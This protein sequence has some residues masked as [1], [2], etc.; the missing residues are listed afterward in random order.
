M[1]QHSIIQ[2][3][4]SRGT[5]TQTDELINRYRSELESYLDKLLWWNDRVNLV[6][7]GVPRETIREHIRHSLLLSTFECFQEN[8]LFLDTGTGGGLPGIPLAITHPDK[9]FVLNDLVTKKC[10]A[11]KQ[12][13]RDLGLHNIGIIDGSIQ[14]LHHDE[15]CILISK[16][17][18]KIGG[19]MEMTTHLSW[20]K[21]VLYKGL[22]FKDELKNISVPLNITCFDLSKGSDFYNGKAI[23]IVEKS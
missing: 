6:S 3:T 19:L 17:A 20:K 10:L 22:D 16:H 9:H 23:I 8:E 21:M 7:R 15:E 14:D 13:A 5:F 18:F 11:I 2:K 1:E 12:I 4:V